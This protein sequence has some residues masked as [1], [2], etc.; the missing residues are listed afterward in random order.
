MGESGNIAYELAKEA[1]IIGNKLDELE[2]I[3]VKSNGENVPLQKILPLWSSYNEI[4]STF[5]NKTKLISELF[6]ERIGNLITSDLDKDT[7]TNFFKLLIE[8]ITP[9]TDWKDATG[10]GLRTFVPIEGSTAITL[11]TGVSSLLQIMMVNIKF[12]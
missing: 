3:Y 6:K 11:K 5:D 1:G 10:E 7:I 4:I 12:F 8:S 2:G 9:I